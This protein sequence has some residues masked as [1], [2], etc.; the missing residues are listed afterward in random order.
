M[1]LYE[2]HNVSVALLILNLGNICRCMISFKHHPFYSQYPLSRRFGEPQIGH[3]EVEKIWFHFLNFTVNTLKP[4]GF[5]SYCAQ[6]HLYTHTLMDLGQL[7]VL[8]MK[9][10]L[11]D[12]FIQLCTVW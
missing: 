2:G 3:F 4:I 8:R 7:Y 5:S 12:C 11:D 6:I 9:E 10:G 1:K